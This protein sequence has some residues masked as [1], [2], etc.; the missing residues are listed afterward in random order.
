MVSG[1]FLDSNSLY[2]PV[3]SQWMQAMVYSER[4]SDRLKRTAMPIRAL[5]GM[6][7]C[8]ISTAERNL[9]WSIS[10]RPGPLR[11]ARVTAAFTI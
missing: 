11:S 3:R 5:T 7:T 10:R 2:G 8:D 9:R 6:R 1:R 4:L